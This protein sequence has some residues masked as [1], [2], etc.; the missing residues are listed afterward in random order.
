MTATPFSREFTPMNTKGI[1]KLIRALSR[2]FAA[3][4]LQGYRD[5]SLR[6][7]LWKKVR[8]FMRNPGTFPPLATLQ[9]Y[10]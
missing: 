3:K 4:V 8:D 9:G 7:E 10:A 6:S 5:P 1:P 2:S